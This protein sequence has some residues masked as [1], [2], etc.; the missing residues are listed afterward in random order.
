MRGLI[1]EL[2]IISFFKSEVET[3]NYTFS[4]I[5][6]H[7]YIC[8]Y[9]ALGGGDAFNNLLLP[10]NPARKT[11]HRTKPLHFGMGTRNK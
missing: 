1:Y 3:Q 6:V 7:M 8:I 4:R 9:P 5:Y 2:R 11:P 10:L